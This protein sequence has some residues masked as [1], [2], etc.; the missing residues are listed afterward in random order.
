[1]HFDGVFF[2]VGNTLVRP[3]PSVGHVC[4]QILLDA[5]YEHSVEA[6]DALLP[7]VDDYY[8]DRYRDDDTFWTSDAGA[9]DV[10]V[11]MYSLLCRRARWRAYT[12]VVPAFER[13]RAA[14]VKVGIVSNWDTRLEGI[15]VGLG[16]GA[17][18]ETVVCSAVEGLRKPDPRI[19]EL[20]CERA[21]VRPERSAHVGDHMYADVIGARAAGMRPV[22]IDRHGH[23][24]APARR[25]VT[26]ITTLDRLEEALS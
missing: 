25:G 3:E 19:F 1:M 6:I 23:V 12:D 13:L 2:D 9:T 18:V 24:G 10:W 15:L 14:G 4:A 17:L 16:L 26:C 11:G 8:E 20:A 5:G 7:V 22:L 21:G